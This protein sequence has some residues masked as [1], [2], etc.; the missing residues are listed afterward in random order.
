MGLKFNKIIG[1]TNINDTIPRYLSSGVFKPHKTKRTISNAMDVS[2]PNNFSRIEKLFN[3][4]SC[5]S[6]CYNGKTRLC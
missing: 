2:N 5:I 6:K 1:S 4:Y 3:G